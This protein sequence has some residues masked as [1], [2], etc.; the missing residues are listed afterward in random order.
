MISI[1]FVDNE[2]GVEA[3]LRQHLRR[4][5]EFQVRTARSGAEALAAIEQQPIDVVVSDY[6]ISGTDGLALLRACRQRYGDLP[7]VFFA[8]S[9]QSERAIEAIEQGVDF[10]IEKVSD[11]EAAFAVLFN[12]CRQ[13]VRRHRAERALAAAEEQISRIVDGS[14]MGTQLYER[15]DDGSLILMAANPAAERLAE[16]NHEALIGMPIEEVFPGLDGTEIPDRLSDVALTGQGWHADLVTYGDGGIGSA[17]EVLAHAIGG[18]RV[19][20]QFIDITERLAL[21]EELRELGRQWETVFQ[22]IGQPAMVLSPDQRVVAVN[23]A[24]ERAIGLTRDELVGRHC[25]EIF[26]GV[27]EPPPS[28]PF[29]GLVESGGDAGTVETVVDALDGTFLVSCTPVHD[30]EGRLEKV[31]HLATEITERVQH[32]QALRFA[33][34]KLAL[35]SNVTRHDLRNRLMGLQ[36]YIRMAERATDP[37][38]RARYRRLIAETA[39]SMEEILAFAADYERVG[40]Q[41]PEW[42]RLDAVVGA[43]LEEVELDGVR[44]AVEV[45]GVEVLAD[46]M[47]RKVFSNLMD[48]SVRHGETV[49]RI[50]VRARRDGDA[51]VIAYEDDG[52]GVPRDEKEMIFWKGFGKNTGLGLYMSSQILAITGIEVSETGT[53]GIGARF[54]LRCPPG[55]WR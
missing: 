23:R 22:A 40:T 13:A 38:R 55:T 12:A 21:E 8:G 35:I 42:Q 43:A 41:A 24:A 19:L 20:V 46:P 39:R 45:G 47:L 32:E 27:P 17:F 51:L 53:P 30:E 28:C 29:R 49:T 26:H 7:F 48:N 18:G 6:Q 10:T 25:A 44:V 34:D 50:R 14:P 36:G 2:P 37:E 15:S 31:I 3:L 11:H 5:P 4:Y 1:L 9:G 16:V 33:N 52:A 54:E